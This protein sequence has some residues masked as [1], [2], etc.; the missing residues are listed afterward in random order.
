MEMSHNRHDALGRRR[1]L[2]SR[3]NLALIGVLAIGAHRLLIGHRAPVVSSMSFPRLAAGPLM[4]LLHG[5]RGHYAH[6]SA[7]RRESDR[8]E[9]SSAVR[10]EQ[11]LR[12]GLAS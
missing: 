9:R 7:G 8:R 1:S 6:R 10:V 12:A 3:F 4:Q 11:D 5:H 2:V